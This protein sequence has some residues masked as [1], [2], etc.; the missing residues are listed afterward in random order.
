M[1]R[2]GQYAPWYLQKHA[3]DPPE[4]SKNPA[5]HGDR[6]VFLHYLGPGSTADLR[7]EEDCRKEIAEV[8]LQHKTEGQF[9]GDIAYNYLVC[10]HGHIYEGR[11]EQRGE[12][13]GGEADPIDGRG[14]NEGFYSILGMIRSDDVASEAMLRAIR[15][16][17]GHLR[18]HVNPHTGK[19]AGNRILPHSF[20]YDTDCPGNLHMYARPGSTIDPPCRGGRPPTSTSTGRRSG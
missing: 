15:D 12:G 3:S 7:T 2:G 16:L 6:G 18:H 19:T 4:A 5:W 14:R 13:N 17:I 10:Q 20:G 11:G 1:P 9:E 8:Y